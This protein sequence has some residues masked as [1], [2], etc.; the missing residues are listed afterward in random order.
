[1]KRLLILPLVGLT[2]AGC[3][4]FAQIPAP[5]TPI[6]AVPA[7]LRKCI[8]DA[9]GVTIPRRTLTVAE[10]E[11]LWKSDRVTIVVLR[12]C[13]KQILAFH[14]ALRKGWR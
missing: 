10:I 11:R 14:D 9:S 5:D 13:G 8:E 4:P 3:D 6:P 7:A 1:M 2:L 12:K